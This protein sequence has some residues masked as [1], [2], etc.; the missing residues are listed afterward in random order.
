[1]GFPE[2]ESDGASYNLTTQRDKTG[3]RL[4]AKVRDARYFSSERNIGF[5]SVDG[6]RHTFLTNVVSKTKSSQ[7]SGKQLVQLY[8]QVPQSFGS[9]NCPL[10]RYH[11]LT[12]GSALM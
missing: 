9:E 12:L 4:R 6:G 5:A 7:N 8:P 1:M 11:T 2:I 3:M 10:K